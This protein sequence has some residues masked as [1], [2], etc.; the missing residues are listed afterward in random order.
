MNPETMNVM[1]A[2]ALKVPVDNVTVNTNPASD[3]LPVALLG[4]VI[5]TLGDVAVMPDPTSVMTT[6]PPVGVGEVGVSVTDIVTDAAPATALLRVMAGRL[7]PRF[8]G[9][10][11]AT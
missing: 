7:A 4:A 3:A 9:A 11:I 8:P 1:A 2:L 6:L 10:V 5:V